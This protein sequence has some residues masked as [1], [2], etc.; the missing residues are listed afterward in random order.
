ML[1]P[2]LEK[3]VATIL[4]ILVPFTFLFSQTPAEELFPT[5]QK[6]E[7][8]YTLSMGKEAGKLDAKGHP[9]YLLGGA[10]CGV[11]GVVFAAIS[12]PEPPASVMHEIEQNK[13]DMYALGYAEAYSKSS[14]KKNVMY[15]LGGWVVVVIVGLAMVQMQTIEDDD[16]SDKH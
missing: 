7:S 10:A 16:D 15:A 3:L 8:E 4:I 6:V 11:L 1:N 5:E 13:G 2:F 9:A 14:R 12:E